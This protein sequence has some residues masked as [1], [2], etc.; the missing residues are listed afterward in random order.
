MTNV[1]DEEIQLLRL[2]VLPE[3][4]RRVDVQLFLIRIRPIAINPL[5]ND[6]LLSPALQLDARGSAPQSSQRVLS[7]TQFGLVLFYV[8]RYI[9]A[10]PS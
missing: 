8:H 4:R 5:M 9:N 3:L 2:L 7:S 1:H 10:S 6:P